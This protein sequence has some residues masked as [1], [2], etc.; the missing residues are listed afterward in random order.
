MPGLIKLLQCQ[1][2]RK[3]CKMA[4]YFPPA[5]VQHMDLCPDMLSPSY[6]P[7]VLQSY[8]PI[9]LQYLDHSYIFLLF[10]FL[11]FIAVHFIFLIT[12][13][14][15][16]FYFLFFFLL[17]Y[18]ARSYIYIILLFPLPNSYNHPTPCLPLLPPTPHYRIPLIW[19]KKHIAILIR[20]MS[21]L[22]PSLSVSATC[23]SLSKHRL[24]WVVGW[25]L[26]RTRGLY[27]VS[28]LFTQICLLSFPFICYVFW[29]IT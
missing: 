20:V 29:L 16:Y 24:S 15:P 22:P 1:M 28:I 8:S 9:V 27:C 13:L 23:S 18:P 26:K 11:F 4:T 7:T 10:I 25:R 14:L 21:S 19:R 3:T 5:F 6:S 2:K 17:Q 12:D